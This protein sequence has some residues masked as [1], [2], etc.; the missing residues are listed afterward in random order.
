MKKYFIISIISFLIGFTVSK[1]TVKE[2]VRY[3]KGETVTERVPVPYPVKETRLSF[4]PQLFWKTDTV[5][6]SEIRYDTVKMVDE[7]L[8]RRD[9]ELTVFDDNR[10]KFIARPTVQYNTLADFS[11]SFTPMI[12]QITRDRRFEPFVVGGTS[13][14]GGGAF[15]NH[16][17]FMMQANKNGGAFNVIYKF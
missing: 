17:G 12:K 5:F 13:G 15:I 3:V 1:T 10:G 2:K 4:V 16:W 11:Y 6:E 7:F 8:L 14:I 9:Y